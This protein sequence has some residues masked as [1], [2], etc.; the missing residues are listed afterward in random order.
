MILRSSIIHLFFTPNNDGQN[1]TW[2]IS[3]LK[4]HPEALVNIYDRFGKLVTQ[5]KPTG[6]GWNG[7]Y[8]NGTK[9]PSSD[10]WFT[11]TFLYEGKPTTY[12]SHF[13][14]IRKE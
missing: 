14:L 10:Y 2:N 6:E 3:D 7:N 12:S 11:V 1:E 13:S 8:K 5:I 9:A 4:N